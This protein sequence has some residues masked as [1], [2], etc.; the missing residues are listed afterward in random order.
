MSRKQEKQM[1]EKNEKREKE[2]ST[3]KGQHMILFWE[4]RLSG[5]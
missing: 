4:N 2:S 1:I 3:S 5:N